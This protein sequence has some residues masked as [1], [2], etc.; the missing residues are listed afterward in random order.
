MVIEGETCQRSQQHRSVVTVYT[1]YC[2]ILRFCILSNEGIYIF[3]M[4]FRKV[5]ISVHSATDWS[6]DGQGLSYVSLLSLA[7][8]TF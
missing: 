2:D 8:S 6:L 5:L 1:T 7:C 4:I 3:L